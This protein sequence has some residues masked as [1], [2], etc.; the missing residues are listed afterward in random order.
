MQY[1]LPANIQNHNGDTYMVRGKLRRLSFASIEMD[2]VEFSVHYEVDGYYMPA[3][4]TD[5]AE[6][7]VCVVKKLEIG[8]QDVTR[9]L[10]DTRICEHI[11]E[12]VEAGWRS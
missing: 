8:G 10:A 6:Y 3:T 11:A 2:G 4:D 7:P 12:K 1:A 9:L 5:P